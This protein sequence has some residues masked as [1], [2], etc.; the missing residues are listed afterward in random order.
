MKTLFLVDKKMWGLKDANRLALDALKKSNY[1]GLERCTT[2][3]KWACG[4]YIAPRHKYYWIYE[5]DGDLHISMP[6]YKYG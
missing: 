1:Y 3:W 6:S 2:Q 4:S 5:F